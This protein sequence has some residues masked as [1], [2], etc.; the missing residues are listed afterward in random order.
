M[1]RI[2]SR[3]RSKRA[4]TLVELIVAMALTSIFAASCVMLIA[5]VSKIY[6]HIKDQGRAQ[7]VA[8]TVIDS[9]RAECARTH[10]SGAGDVWITDVTAV[11]YSLPSVPI[12]TSS[13]NVLVIRR[14]YDHCET[15]CTDYDIS[16][17][18][19]DLIGSVR[20]AE[21]A[22]LEEGAL[23]Q[24]GEV[25]SRAIYRML[26]GADPEF[27]DARAGYVHFGYFEIDPNATGNVLAINYYDFTNPLSFASYGKDGDYTVGL[28]FHDLTLNTA[29]QPAFVQCDVSVYFRHGTV[30]V[31]TRSNVVLCFASP[32]L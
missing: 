17:E 8:D 9:I 1:R 29:G 11:A 27:R 12:N 19:L 21:L 10:I 3:K 5:P 28:N 26:N 22:S 25:T 4:L 2:V 15:I 32:V 24:E 20:T 18:S 7:L 16:D 31:Y 30:P 14:N 23:P 6:T 13:G